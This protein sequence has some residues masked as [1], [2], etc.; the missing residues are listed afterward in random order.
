MKPSKPFSLNTLDWKKWR[1]DVLYFLATPVIL[2]TTAILGIVQ[3][4][5]HVFSLKDLIPSQITIGAVIGYVLTQI[6]NLARK[7][8]R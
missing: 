8:V 7:W 5:N 6:Q 4:D 2:Y 1:D 3:Q